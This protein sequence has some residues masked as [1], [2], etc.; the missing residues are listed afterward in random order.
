MNTTI[1]FTK[2]IIS[3]KLTFEQAVALQGATMTD[4][5]KEGILTFE[6]ACQLQ[7]IAGEVANPAPKKAAPKKAAPKR[8]ASKKSKSKKAPK[9]EVTVKVLDNGWKYHTPK[10]HDLTDYQVKRLDNALLKVWEAGYEHAEWRVEGTWAWIYTFSGE[11]G[12]GY[13]PAF[14]NAMKK[15]FSG[16][17]WEYC[18]SR[19]AM[20]YKDFI[21]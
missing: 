17:N 14:K 10:K 13:S 11:K 2:A 19:G 7:G 4:A 6:E 21:K 16:S 15:A 18:A 9:P 8:K 3:G 20:V 12:T 5:I 1:D